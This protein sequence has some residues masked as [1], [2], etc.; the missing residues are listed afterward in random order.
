MHLI[1]IVCFFMI[2]LML[3]VIRRTFAKV[4]YFLDYNEL[5]DHFLYYKTIFLNK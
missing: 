4:K 3:F 1:R 2:D 5:K